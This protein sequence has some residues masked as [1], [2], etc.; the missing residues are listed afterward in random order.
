[1]KG[2]KGLD[3]DVQAGL[4]QMQENSSQAMDLFGGTNTASAYN[5]YMQ[6]LAIVNKINDSKEMFTDAYGHASADGSLNEIAVTST[7]GIWIKDIRNGKIGI[8]SMSQL[9]KNMDKWQPLTNQDLLYERRH[10]PKMAFQDTLLNT[11]QQSTSM[12]DI[13][14]TITT[15]TNS[16]GSTEYSTN[17][18]QISNGQEVAGG[19]KILKKIGQE[20][21]AN[22][23]APGA[24]KV[25]YKSQ[26][27][28]D[29]ARAAE[30]AIY[31]SLPEN[32]K[33]LLASK[34][35][36]TSD[37]A[38]KLIGLIVSKD[39]TTSDDF[40]TTWDKG[41]TTALFG[42][43]ATDKDSH[44]AQKERLN[45]VTKAL[46]GVGNPQEFTLAGGTSNAFHIFARR[47]ELTDGSQHRLAPYSTFVD[48]GKSPVADILDFSK[49]SLGDDP[50]NENFYNHVM[51]YNPDL[52]TMDL[53][54]TTKDI[55]GKLEQVPDFDAMIRKDAA[56]KYIMEHKI[57]DPIKIN[58]IYQSPKYH[59]PPLQRE[60]NGE[61]KLAGDY[62]RFAGVQV[63]ADS[64]ALQDQ[65]G[66]SQNPTFV[67]VTDSGEI[68]QYVNREKKIDPKYTLSNG[69]L[70]GNKG[71]YK[72]TVFIPVNGDTSD[73][74]IAT[75]SDEPS[76]KSVDDTMR[77]WNVR[78]YKKPAP[79][80]T[81]Q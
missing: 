68:Q 79:F 32:Q 25:S 20:N 1:M 71:I 57:T 17:G 31:A 61:W 55:N 22:M 15:L 69:F 11:V 37:G 36:G 3:S 4:Q 44:S 75:P 23:A 10:N 63:I 66:A 21:A 50:I 30:S 78:D 53:P 27:N 16:L 9:K 6:N 72:G 81:L 38:K 29:Q 64:Q 7:G 42:G 67:P 14:K 58:S 77:T 49:A 76:L 51:I 41:V 5:G 35:D 62:K 34:T 13:L 56:D 52:Y 43:K 46:Y 70:S 2:I 8:V 26:S 59:L 74:M 18:Y 12:G 73:A 39:I 65:K 54:V 19:I 33:V 60:A 47:S 24:Y 48:V 80:S 40:N 28:M 45:P